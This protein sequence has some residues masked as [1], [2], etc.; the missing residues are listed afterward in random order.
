MSDGDSSDPHSEPLAQLERAF[1]EEY[2]HRSRPA[3]EYPEELA[4][5]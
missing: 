2:L 3:L 4:A 1:I 5:G